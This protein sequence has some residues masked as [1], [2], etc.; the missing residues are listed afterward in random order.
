MEISRSQ[1]IPL[2]PEDKLVSIV[3]QLAKAIDQDYQGTDA[4]V[5][6]GVLKGSFI[7]LADLIRLIQTPIRAIEFMKL[8]SYGDSTISSGQA[9]MQ[10]GVTEAMLAKQHVLL[11]EDIVDTG[12]T[13]S[14]TLQYLQQYQ[15]ASLR[16]CTLLD[17]PSRRKV[18]VQIDYVGAIVPDQFIVGYGIDYNEKY[19]QLPAIY[20][21]VEDP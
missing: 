14:M 20:G 3:Q 5:I 13:M 2:I 19:R 17:K 6:I 18:P 11:V 15:P 10:L 16:L 4:L 21:L 9:L 8:S 1:L 7:F 12:V